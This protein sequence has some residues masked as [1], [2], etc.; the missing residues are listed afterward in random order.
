MDREYKMID[1]TV[2]D[3]GPLRSDG[4][5]YAPKDE[6]KISQVLTVFIAWSD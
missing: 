5:E 4:T 1:D 2:P 6:L 3:D